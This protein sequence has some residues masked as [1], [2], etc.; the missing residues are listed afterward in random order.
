MGLRIKEL[1]KERNV[2]MKQIALNI[3]IM[4]ENFPKVLNGN[5]TIE[6]LQKIAD[7]LNVHI[8]ELFEHPA[9]KELTAFIEY[10]KEIYKA[11]SL[12]QL[13]KVVSQIENNMIE[14][15]PLTQ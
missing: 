11:D 12:E 13:K 3:G 10:K 15:D 1:C 2:S 7:A 6:T 8:T 9:N 4:P 14:E 5:P